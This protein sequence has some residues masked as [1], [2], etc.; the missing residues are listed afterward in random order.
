MEVANLIG[1]DYKFERPIILLPIGYPPEQSKATS[2]R[3]L[4]D[5]VHEEK[6]QEK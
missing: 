4:K 2:R 5:L 6:K 3:K 1:A